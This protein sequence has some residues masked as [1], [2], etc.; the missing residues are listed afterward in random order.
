MFPISSIAPPLWRWSLRLPH[1]GLCT[2][3]GHPSAHGHS[4]TSRAASPTS[5]VELVVAATGDADAAGMAVVDEDRRPPGLHVDVRREAADVPAIAHRQQ[6]QDRD[7]G[8]LGGVQGAELDVRRQRLGT[9]ELVGEHVP[10]RLGRVA[11]LGQVEGDEVEGLVA[12]AVADPLAL[13]GDHLLADRDDPEVELDAEDVA[14][15]LDPLDVDVGLLARLRVPV[16]AE[17]LDDRAAQVEVELAN[18]V[19]AT[20]VQVDGARVDGRERALGLDGAEQLAAARRRR[21]SPQSADAERRLTPPA[22]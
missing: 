2:Q 4:P 7:L 18:L 19:G 11:L 1:F 16:A 6:R 21:R 17:R 9:G 3:E 12:V 14:L 20:E 5:A 22:G 13:E 10:E 8:V 15:R